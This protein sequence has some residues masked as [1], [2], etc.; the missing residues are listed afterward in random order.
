MVLHLITFI[1]FIVIVAHGGCKNRGTSKPTTPCPTLVVPTFVGPTTVGPTTVG[2]TTVV[3]TTL[4]PSVSMYEHAVKFVYQTSGL[5]PVQI[6]FLF[7]DTGNAMFSMEDHL[8]WIAG[9]KAACPQAGI[10]ASDFTGFRVD[11]QGRMATSFGGKK[12]FLERVW[13]SLFPGMY[14]SEPNSAS[15][16]HYNVNIDGTVG[17]KL[18]CKGGGDTGFK[19]YKLVGTGIGRPYK[20]SAMKDG[21]TWDDLFNDLKMVCPDQWSRLFPGHEYPTVGFATFKDI[22]VFAAGRSDRLFKESS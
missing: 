5:N 21:D 22:Y 8:R 12:I 7:T 10:A 9:A 19:K 18:D 13:H 14:S 20:L 6:V 3:G 15:K 2:P 1:S 4:N 16:M 11:V 17:V